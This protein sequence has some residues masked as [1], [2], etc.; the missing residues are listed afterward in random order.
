MGMASVVIVGL[1]LAGA[2]VVGIR[3]AMD[4]DEPIVVELSA[5]PWS[6]EPEDAVRWSDLVVIGRVDAA[7]EDRWTTDDGNEPSEFRRT[8]N[9]EGH[10]IYR[11]ATVAI[12]GVIGGSYTGK[13][14]KVTVVG[15]RRR[16]V[17]VRPEGFGPELQPGARVMLFLTRPAAEETWEFGENWTRIQTYWLDEEAG[18][19]SAYLLPSI[20]VSELKARVDAVIDSLGV[21]AR[22]RAHPLR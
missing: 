19:A 6:V 5:Y 2:L 20:P 13:T 15:G 16:G 21:A 11:T 22:E 17:E 18:V 10:F 3:T 1:L 8:G 14:I 9:S 7:G 12:E 4:E